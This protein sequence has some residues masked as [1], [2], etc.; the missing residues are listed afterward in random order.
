M[1]DTGAFDLEEV[2]A[3]AGLVG[4]DRVDAILSYLKA[5]DAGARYWSVIAINSL[6]EPGPAVTAALQEVLNDP[7]PSVQIAAAEAL[8]RLGHCATAVPVLGNWVQD[9][10]PWVALQA[11][12]S[13][14]EIGPAAKPLV[15]VMLEVQKSCWEVP[16]APASTRTS[17]TP[18]LPAGPW[19]RRCNSAHIRF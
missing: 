15:P 2:M 9:D 14:V 13:L 4:T 8:C 11:A 5:G 10:R 6:P 3:S 18:P 19:K 12:R 7:S 17:S 1:Q 16:T